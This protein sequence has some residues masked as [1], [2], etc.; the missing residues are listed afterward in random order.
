MEGG[1]KMNCGVYCRVSSINQE[2]EG[3]SLDSQL[4]ACLGK[5]KELGYELNEDYV[6][7][8]VYSGLEL[9]R[10]LLTE[11][12]QGIQ[13]KEI[14]AICCYS[15][16]RLSRDPLHL[17]LIADE[18]DKAGIKLT[19]VTE[20]L[21]NSME[22]Q[23]LGFVR[24]WASKLEAIRLRERS[25]RG[26]RTTALR[27]KIP[28][29]R[30]LYGYKYILGEGI[31]LVNEEEAKW[32]RE[33]YKWLVEEHLS[34][35]AIAKRLTASGVPTPRGGTFWR[36]TTI[37]RIAKN[38]S[39]TGKTFAF[40]MEFKEPHKR[41]KSNTKIKKTGIV[42]KPKEE[43]I[44]IPNAT[45]A[46]IS[47]EL[48]GEAQKILKRNK[49]LATRN[50]KRQYLLS[51]HIICKRCGKRYVGHTRVYQQSN[52]KRYEYRYY[53]C[54]AS[55]KE[56]SL[57]PCDNKGLRA[58]T[59][60]SA[61]WEQ[62]E[63]LL[64]KPELVLAELQDRQENS[65]SVSHLERNLEVTEAQLK[66]KEREK[67]RIHRVFYLMGDEERFKKDMG[68][69]AEGI[70]SLEEERANLISRIEASQKF[71]LDVEGIKRACELVKSNLNSLDYASKRLALEALGIKI[72]VEGSDIN[73]QGVIPIQRV[74]I[75]SASSTS[76][77]KGKVCVTR[78]RQQ[79][80]WSG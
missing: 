22:G 32:V 2:R 52:G 43:W 64:S 40:T 31:R 20:P 18:C 4:E 57:I 61:V 50:A 70:K 68:I 12:R 23:L 9:E 74:P 10:P 75:V 51:G 15:T 3:T 65:H 35:L 29:G 71:D 21:D 17:L 56:T 69:L 53:I 36:P 46:I 7:K 58:S 79:E 72:M 55:R 66:H 47:E 19:F 59:I 42:W 60:E 77:R 63:T 34:L 62:I 54:G 25:I 73:I 1:Q 44:E 45:P 49:E 41:M 37:H 76:M 16:D 38:L 30:N 26:K 39:Y 5:A 11:L 8:E 27:G 48:F 6:L 28:N 13:N 78:N 14:E 80:D 67:E 33:I 24:G